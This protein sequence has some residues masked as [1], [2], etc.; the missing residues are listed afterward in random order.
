[1]GLP[2]TL[3]NMNQFHNGTSYVGQISEVTLPSLARKFEGYRGG[4]MDGEI[5]IDLG[6]EPIEFEWRAGGHISSIYTGFAA[7]TH[8][9]ELIRWVGAY[10]DDGTAQMKAVEIVVRG[11]HQSIEPGNAKP[12][13]Q[14][15]ETVKTAAS[16]Y[17]LTVD[18]TVLVEIDI[19]NLICRVG[20]IDRHAE[21]RA[22]LGI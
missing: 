13:T 4:G 10:Q 14:T 1:M 3:K 19:P 7:A 22:I 5:Q 15:E 2:A 12:G 8:D 6:Q 9:A 21:L 16:Y 17:K 11:R 20:G 18:G